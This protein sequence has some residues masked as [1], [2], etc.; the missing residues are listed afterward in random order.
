MT[1][2][3]P[4]LDATMPLDCRLGFTM[5]RTETHLSNTLI[6][7]ECGDNKAGLRYFRLTLFSLCSN[8]L[9]ADYGAQ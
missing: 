6:D 5:Q 9:R 1:I 8:A 7:H 3:L 2:M 4:H